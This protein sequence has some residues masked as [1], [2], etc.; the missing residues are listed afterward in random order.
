MVGLATKGGRSLV[1]ELKRHGLT[2]L[3][4]SLRPLH[5]FCSSVT[6]CVSLGLLLLLTFFG[7]YNV[8]RSLRTGIVCSRVADT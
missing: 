7:L 1:P 3:L 6:A 5:T 8:V 2:G 4:L